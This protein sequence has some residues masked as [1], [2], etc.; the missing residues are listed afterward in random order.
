MHAPSPRG[1]CKFKLPRVLILVYYLSGAVR[2][3]RNWLGTIILNKLLYK[4]LST[5]TSYCNML[6]YF[7]SL[8]YRTITESTSTS[9]RAIIYRATGNPCLVAKAPCPTYLLVQD[10]KFEAAA[11][12]EF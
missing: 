5:L 1:N 3:P 8:A 2:C 7:T 6:H 10:L 9:T 12:H 4:Y 11:N